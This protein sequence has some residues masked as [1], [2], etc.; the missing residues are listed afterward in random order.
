MAGDVV[1]KLT[2]SKNGVIVKEID[3]IVG[4]DI[5]A[6]SYGDSLKEIISNW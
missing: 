6:I 5:D 4:S 2:I 3:L 1:G